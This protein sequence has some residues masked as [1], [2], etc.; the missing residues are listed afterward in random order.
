[1]LK[2]YVNEVLHVGLTLHADYAAGTLDDLSPLPAEKTSMDEKDYA[3]L[4]KTA[5][6]RVI[7]P[8]LKKLIGQLPPKDIATFILALESGKVLAHSFEGGK[9]TSS[10][11]SS[12]VPGGI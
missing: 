2:G 3:K 1:M 9:W 12:G 6:N 8:E 7:L 4:L 10:A 11:F 5:L